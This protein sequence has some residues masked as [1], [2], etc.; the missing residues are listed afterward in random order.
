MPTA[1][2]PHLQIVLD[3]HG[4]P[5]QMRHLRLLD[6]YL[7]RARGSEYV[8]GLIWITRS[9]LL[10]DFVGRGEMPMGY[11]S[12]HWSIAAEKFH[13]PSFDLFETGRSRPVG[14]L[15]NLKIPDWS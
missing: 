8:A 5:A 15:V 14:R 9:D 6:C 10:D 4:E 3:C 2:A 13:E 7:A 12:N 1:N 11:P